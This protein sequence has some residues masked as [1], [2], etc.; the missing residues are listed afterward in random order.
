MRYSFQAIDEQGR[1][2]RGVL[3]AENEEEARELLLGENVFPKRL[4][5]AEEGVKVTWA[6]KGRIKAQ[7]E[8]RG[9]GGSAEEPAKAVR[10]LFS[11][12]L[13]FGMEGAPV[14]GRAGLTE[15]NGFVFEAPGRRLQFAR[16]EVETA[17]IGGFPGKV[18]RITL[19]SGKMFEFRAGVLLAA[20]SAREIARTLKSK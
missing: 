13:L 19:L 10:A 3:R 4:E 14:A 16:E 8:Q 6:P 17:A 9:A 15:Q 11:T 7:Y 20:G 12:T 1:V 18:L 5:E 2:I